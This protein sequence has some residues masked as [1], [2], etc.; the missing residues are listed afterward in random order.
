M[1][2]RP[3]VSRS[4]ERGDG[5]EERI[6]GFKVGATRFSEERKGEIVNIKCRGRGLVWG[7]GTKKKEYEWRMRRIVER[8]SWD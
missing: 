8:E 5:D 2:E 7:K 1:G 6:S 3:R 4:I